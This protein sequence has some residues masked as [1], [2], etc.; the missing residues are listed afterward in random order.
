MLALE[1][2]QLGLPLRPTLEAL[3]MLKDRGVIGGRLIAV[4]GLVVL[5]AACG[6]TS[7]Q[8]CEWCGTGEAP[9]SVSSFARIAPESEPG[10]RLVVAGFVY[11]YDGVTPAPDVLIYVYHTNAQ[12]IYPKR[13][14]E[15]GNG[16][17]HGYLRGWLKTDAR[18]HYRF[19]TIRPAAYESHGGEP[20]HIHY[21]VQPPG[22]VEYWLDG[23]WFADDPRVTDELI[24]TLPRQGGFTNVMTVSRDSLGIWNGRRDIQLEDYGK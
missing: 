3:K 14:D 13:G 6:K 21:T 24:A 20:A 18:G 2:R 1:L 4:M 10:D 15:V 17:R 7:A 11:R 23:A 16:R 5:A 19:E 9:D 22:G 8:D 12:G